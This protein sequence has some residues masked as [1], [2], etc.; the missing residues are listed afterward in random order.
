MTH[1]YKSTSD[2]L[3]CE[4][5]NHKNHTRK[6]GQCVR[7]EKASDLVPPLSKIMPLYHANYTE[8]DKMT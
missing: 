5:G 2:Y 8:M 4:T 1:H 3:F 7:P 6:S